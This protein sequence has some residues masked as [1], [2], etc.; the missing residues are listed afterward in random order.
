M[1][2]WRICIQKN[3][4]T[5][6]L[7]ENPSALGRVMSID[8]PKAKPILELAIEVFEKLNFN[9]DTEEGAWI[10]RQDKEIIFIEKCMF[11]VKVENNHLKIWTGVSNYLTREQI[12]MIFD[13]IELVEE[14]DFN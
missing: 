13:F 9:C 10:V 11:T 6:V 3:K 5:L 2:D 7:F 8:N 4:S 14:Y 1:C 12:N